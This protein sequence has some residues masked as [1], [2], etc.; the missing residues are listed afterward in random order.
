MALW[1]NNLVQFARL[2]CEIRAN[3]VATPQE[4]TDLKE[5]MDL[6]SQDV[7]ALFDRAEV[8]WES[9]K[10]ELGAGMPGVTDEHS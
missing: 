4:W 1:D 7:E 3:I 8:V 2:L 9:A 5:S 10:M 6:P